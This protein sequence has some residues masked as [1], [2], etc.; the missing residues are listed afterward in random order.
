MR[1]EALLNILATVTQS[2]FTLWQLADIKHENARKTPSTELDL[3]LSFAD[4]TLACSD[5]SD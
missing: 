2:Q 3:E 5:I 4:V 1:E